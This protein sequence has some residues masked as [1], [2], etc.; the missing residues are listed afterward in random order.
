MFI[1]IISDTHSLCD[2]HVAEYLSECDEIWH[3]GDIGDDQ[4]LKW[5]QGIGPTLRAV[6]GNIDNGLVRRLCP[7]RLVFDCAGAKVMLTHIGGYPGKYAPGIMSAIRRENP[8]IFVSGHSHILRV[9]YDD[10]L[11]LLHINPGAAGNQGWQKVR[12]IVRF[13]IDE[14]KP[15][16]LEVIELGTRG[17]R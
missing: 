14:G 13:H 17:A 12:T 8:D 11:N 6:C 3:A 10:R 2:S 15:H 9:M 5:L 16:D 1:G 7:E 4:T